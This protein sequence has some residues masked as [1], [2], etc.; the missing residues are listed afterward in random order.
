MLTHVQWFRPNGAEVLSV[1]DFVNLYR[2]QGVTAA[3]PQGWKAELPKNDNEYFERM[4]NALFQ[5]GLNWKMIQNKWPN[6]KRAF[7]NFSIEKVSKF[8][9]RDVKELMKDTGIVRNEKKIRSVI[10]NAQESLNVRKEFGSFGKYVDSFGKNHDRLIE[11]LR[12]RFRH[13]GES[14]ARTFL[15]MSAVKL[16][17]TSEEMAWHDQ[18]MKKK[19]KR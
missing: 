7:A 6:F 17:P 15:Y 13:L 16:K 18:M 11:D 2:F 5:A 19:K 9:E 12:G 14:S 3:M 8:N 4:S 10:A 1:G